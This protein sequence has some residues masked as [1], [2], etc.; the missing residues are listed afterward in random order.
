M[1]EV[2]AHYIIQWFVC[3]HQFSTKVNLN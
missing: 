2:G 1:Y 3:K